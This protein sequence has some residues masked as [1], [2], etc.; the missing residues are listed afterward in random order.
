[1]IEKLNFVY[2][3]WPEG[4]EKPNPNGQKWFPEDGAWCT[5]DTPMEALKFYDYKNC[6]LEEVA[7]NRSKNFYYPVWHRHSLYNRFFHDGKIPVGLDIIGLIKQHKNLYLLLIN[8]QEYE[9][10]ECFSAAQETFAKY[11]LDLSKIFLVSNN[12]RSFEYKINLGLKINVHGTR[13]EPLSQIGIPK[14]DWVEN[15]EGKFFMTHNHSI[16]DHRVGLIALLKKYDILKDVDWSF[17]KLWNLPNE[18]PKHIFCRIFNRDEMEWLKPEMDFLINYGVKKSDYESHFE[19]LDILTMDAPSWW[20]IY[21]AEQY[22]NTYFNITTETIFQSGDIHV[23]E[24]TYKPFMNLQFPMILATQHHLKYVRNFWG[25]DFFDDVIDHSYDDIADPHD[26]LFKFVEEIKRIQDNKDFFI[27]F[28]KNNKERFLENQRMVYSAKN[29]YDRAFLKALVNFNR[30]EKTLNLVYDNW[31]YDKGEPVKGNAE[32]LY[33][34][35]HMCLDSVVKSLQI[36]ESYIKRFPVEEVKNLPEEKFLYFVTMIPGKVSDNILSGKLPIPKKVIDLWRSCKN[37]YIM[38]MNEQESESEDL[39]DHLDK[40]TKDLQLE[41]EQL[42]ISNNNTKL[43]ERKQKIGTSINVHSTVRLPNFTAAGFLHSAGDLRFKIEKEGGFFM[44]QNR[45]ARP[46]RYAL[47]CLL[48]KMGLLEEVDWSLV[49]GW[50]FTKDPYGWISQIFNDNDIEEMKDDIDFFSSIDQKK[51]RYEEKYSW[52]DDRD[53]PDNVPWGQNHDR[54]QIENSYF[55]IATETQFN[56]ELIHISEKSFKPFY[57]FQ[58][59]L[60]LASPFHIS[61]I[62]K[63]YNFDFFD[64][65]IDHSYDLEENHRERLFKFAKEIKRIIDNKEFFKEFYRNNQQRFIENQKKLLE[66]MKDKSDENF[67][68]KLVDII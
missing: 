20:N 24:K 38:I 61:E 5:S 10:F 48:R 44:C 18:D 26:R 56:S 41:Q 3:D 67:L 27:D 52:F 16:R 7:K 14:I 55:N 37:L 6:R 66:K 53:N 34:S 31:D 12:A 1:M 54:E 32:D 68:K 64:D 2:D 47:L 63:G 49:Q 11:Q 19:R 25:Y 23:T 8:E 22:K 30:P 51:C 4:Q 57:C 35:F 29:L 33:D 42:W 40:W 28:Y 43:D 15:K 45:R 62:R 58:F 50:Q 9:K 46:H 59:P 39:V 65:V 60:I 36:E 21:N 13:A 17:L